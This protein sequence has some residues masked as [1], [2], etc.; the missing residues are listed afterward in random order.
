MNGSNLLTLFRLL[1]GACLL[2]LAWHWGICGQY[3]VNFP[4]LLKATAAFLASMM[5]L[6]SYLF[7]LVTKP[8][9][10]LADWIFFPGEHLRKPILNRKLPAHYLKEER[11]EEALAEYRKILKYYPEETEAWEKAIWLEAEIFGR[12]NEA[13]KLVRSARRRGVTLDS[14]ILRLLKGDA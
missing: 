3:P 11:Y 9:R 7:R 13:V 14:R 4:L 6:W 1:I 8:F 10:L 2:W 12:T 5:I